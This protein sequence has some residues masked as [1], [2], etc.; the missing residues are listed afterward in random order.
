MAISK[1]DFILDLYKGFHIIEYDKTYM[2]QAKGDY[3][4]KHTTHLVIT[5]YPINNLVNDKNL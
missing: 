2:Y 3:D 1:T 5:N 4:S